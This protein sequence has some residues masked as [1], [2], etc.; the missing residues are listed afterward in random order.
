M[1]KFVLGFIVF[2]CTLMVVPIYRYIVKKSKIKCWLKKLDIKNHEAIFDKLYSATNGF[3]IS[4]QARQDRDAFEYTY[5]EI[6]FI[7]FVA[8]ISLTHPN[9]NT[10]FYDLGS[11]TGRAVLAC[12][13]VF[14]M[15]SCCGVELFEGLYEEAIKQK[16]H[17]SRL[18]GYEKKADLISF[19]HEDFLNVDL[20]NATLIF[21]NST[22]FVGL[23][24]Q[25]LNEHLAQVALGAIIITVSKKLTSSVFEV[26]KTT[27][28]NMSWGV[29]TVYIHE[30]RGYAL[31]SN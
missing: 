1:I 3:L 15:E 11:G 30:Y 21:I 23:T 6:E 12:A 22:A 28:I 27:Q 7:S 18:P 4:R 19:I 14:D 2:I 5:G 13:M 29:A 31:E 8:L 9:Q 24:W 20:S 25:L 26:K 10:K 16:K 17:L